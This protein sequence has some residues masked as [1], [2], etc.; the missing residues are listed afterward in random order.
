MRLCTWAVLATTLLTGC[1]TAT[2]TEF[3]QCE[4]DFQ[5]SL[6]EGPPQTVVRAVGA[7]LTQPY[8]TVVQFDGTNAT[9]L[10][11]ER[12]DCSACDACV[13]EAV[14]A[15][16]CDPC[17]TCTECDSFCASCVETVS[18]E[19]PDIEEGPARVVILNRFG[20]SGPEPFFV[21]AGAGDTDTDVDTDGT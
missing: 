6:A 4:L 16:A 15:E 10:D 13:L 9:V 5:L 19:V 12:V 18:F 20:Q 14:D 21:T 2:T 11:I 7:R 1:P 8:D 3:H 17:G